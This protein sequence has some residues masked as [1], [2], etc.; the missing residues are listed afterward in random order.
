MHMGT[1]QG[2]RQDCLNGGWK[3]VFINSLFFIDEVSLVLSSFTA[4]SVCEPRVI[5]L[6]TLYP[7]V[8]SRVHKVQKSAGV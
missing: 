4:Q 6:S 3:L 5:C 7:V 1:V 8:G 2:Y